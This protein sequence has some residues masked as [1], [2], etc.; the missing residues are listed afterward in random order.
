MRDLLLLNWQRKL[1]ALIVAFIIW[2]FVHHS[3]MEKKTISNVP[4]RVV[5]SPSDKTIVGL[6]P[7]GLLSKRMTLTLT[8]AK[9]VIEEIGT[10]DVEVLVD[11]STLSD[12]QGLLVITK[13][14]LISLNPAI[15]LAEEADLDS[16]SEYPIKLSKLITAKVPIRV[17]APKGDA[18]PG[19][20]FLDIWPQKLYQN[21]TGPEE[22]VL[23][24]M[25][26]GIDLDYDLNAVSKYE[27]DKI[28][29]SRANLHDDEVSFPIPNSWKK[30]PIPF[31][32]NSMEE[33]NDPKAKIL[34]IDYLRKETLPIERDIPVRVF[35]PL[36]TSNEY[37]PAKTPLLIEDPL[38]EKN[39]I[40]YISYPLYIQNVS[41]L[42][43]EVIRDHME[44][45]ITAGPDSEGKPLNW[46]IEVISPQDLEDEY[47]EKLVDLHSEN[48]E[49][50]SSHSSKRESHLRSR[51][52]DYLNH[53]TLYVEKDKKFQMESHLVN[54]KII[55]LPFSTVNEPAQKPAALPTKTH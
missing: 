26:E 32:N 11:A 2:L 34:H 1:A 19:Y 20:V 39:G 53:L 21:V 50:E 35:Y 12:D 9:G 45:V 6:Q 4:I 51:F 47:V 5:N 22:Q 37:N 31:R 24:L 23:A 55:V 10:G 29:T 15:D 46:S 42:F 27:L 14:N 7:N 33:L 41:R 18:A 3:I 8:G 28:P 54:N 13:K 48:G 40:A 52:Q 30:I 44:I 43:L 16:Y 38:H 25:A 17:S 49:Q 36:E